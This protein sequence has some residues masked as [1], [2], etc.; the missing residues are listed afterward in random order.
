[1]EEKK[2]Q[3]YK[4]DIPG[5]SR[6]LLRE[7]RA[8]ARRGPRPEEVRKLKDLAEE[9]KRRNKELERDHYVA[10]SLLVRGES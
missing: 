10:I 8:T 4:S 1:M 2:V 6:F 3:Q 5:T 9:Q 7:V